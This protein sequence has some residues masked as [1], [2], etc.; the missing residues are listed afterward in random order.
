MEKVNS[1][2]LTVEEASEPVFYCRSCHSLHIVTDETMA[3]GDWDGS[4]CGKCFSTDI[5][6]C[7][8]GEWLAEEER[9]EAKRR[10]IEWNR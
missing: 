7:P 9:R 6:E 1:R 10:E 5:G 3:V 2:A 4:H 8:F